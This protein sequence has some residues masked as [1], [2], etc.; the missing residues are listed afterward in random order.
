MMRKYLL[1]TFAV[2]I[3][4]LMQAAPISK[5][6]AAQIA[7]RYMTVIG[8]KANDMR[9]VDNS[10]VTRANARNVQ[11]NQAY[12]A[13][14]AADGQ[15][16]I[17]VSGDDMMP[18]IVGY[19]KTESLVLDDSECTLTGS[20]QMPGRNENFEFYL[21]CYT[22]YVELVRKGI[23]A[24]PR[25]TAEGEVV[26]IVSPLIKT[27]WSQ[28]YPYNMY[29]PK[30]VGLSEDFNGHMPVGCVAVA[31]AQ[32]MNYW[33]WPNAINTHGD[34]LKATRTP[35]DEEGNSV[36]GKYHTLTLDFTE[37][38]PTPYDWENMPLNI[39]WNNNEGLEDYDRKAEEV[40]RLMR[41]VA[42]ASNMCWSDFAGASSIQRGAL[43]KY[44]DYSRECFYVASSALPYGAADTT[45][46]SL[47]K[48][49]LMKKQPVL[50][51]GVAPSSGHAF[52]LDGF[53]SADRVHVNWG[54]GYDGYYDG[55]FDITC[56]D[57]YKDVY[58]QYAGLYDYSYSGIILHNLHP[59]Y[60]GIEEN[61]EPHITDVQCES[62]Y[63]YT[64]DNGFKNLMDYSLN[65]IVNKE[66]DPMLGVYFLP[67]SRLIG[68]D[69]DYCYVITAEDGTTDT[70]EVKDVMQQEDLEQQYLHSYLFQHFIETDKLFEM[71]DGLYS[72]K[73]LFNVKNDKG[74]STGYN[75]VCSYW[76]FHEFYLLKRGEQLLFT[77]NPDVGTGIREIPTA[78]SESNSQQ[79]NIYGMPVTD[80]YHGIVI[81]NGRKVIR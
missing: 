71:E 9:F 47:I 67:M 37:Q 65:S 6:K 18:E 23:V 66:Q 21:E 57:A 64:S 33:Q 20:G 34:L 43:V 28:T 72:M 41:D 79:Y 32:V 36:S 12:Y 75:M 51:T 19:S 60:K 2:V 29:A 78:A 61:V 8:N 1:V 40:G 31:I 63:L 56:L 73:L 26:E 44:F 59:N 58:P 16:F 13:F 81:K 22:H 54:W 38:A 7:A 11:D 46:I 25:K 24:P 55:W 50:Y 74:L 5:S 68:T 76:K 70:L 17:I 62:L 35:F 48:E 27:I 10:S 3:C 80:G 45:W 30:N 14:N 77:S 4:S 53:D 49:D 52:V 15:G 42:Y 69:F 39:P